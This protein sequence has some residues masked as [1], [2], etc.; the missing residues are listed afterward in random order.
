[1]AAKEPAP[2]KDYLI[3]PSF[4]AKFRS[5]RAQEIITE[6]LKTKLTGVTYHADN[7]STWTREIADDI[8]LKLK[9][10]DVERYKFVVQVVI[11]EQRGEGVRM[12]CRCFWDP[13]TDSYATAE[14]SNGSIF[15]VAAAFGVYLY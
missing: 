14:F 12:G 15:C 9:E 7:T 3:E 5:G 8:K 10:L 11:G 2:Q 4:N 1:M 13:N 6:V